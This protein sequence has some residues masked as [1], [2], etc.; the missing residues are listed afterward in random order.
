MT[1]HTQGAACCTPSQLRRLNGVLPAERAASLLV[2]SLAWSSEHSTK[3]LP[4]T[5][6]ALTHCWANVEPG[7]QALLA[8][9]VLAQTQRALVS[10]LSRAGP[11]AR[12]PGGRSDGRLASQATSPTH[13]ALISSLSK[14]GGALLPGSTDSL[15]AAS[16]AQAAGPLMVQ[17]LLY[18]G[19]AGVGLHSG[20]AR[21]CRASV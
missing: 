5:L 8:P 7:R 3:F 16:V 19:E 9:Q 14:A 18:A 12:L 6:Q 20:P 4:Q 15:L 17:A 21:S 13:P 1:V 10:S 11:A 2:Q